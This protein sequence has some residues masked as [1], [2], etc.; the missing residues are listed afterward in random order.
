MRKFRREITQCEKDVQGLFKQAIA[1]KSV[2]INYSLKV[3]L[4]EMSLYQNF[5]IIKFVNDDDDPRNENALRLFM[6]C[7]QRHSLG[8]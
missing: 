4:F 5:L 7:V 2:Q 8:N 3:V 1:V 6:R